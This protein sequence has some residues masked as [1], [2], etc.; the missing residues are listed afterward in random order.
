MIDLKI[1]LID[2]NPIYIPEKGSVDAACYDV[3]AREIIKVNDGYYKVKLGFKSEIPVGFDG[4][5]V[6]RS[7]ITDTG[8]FIPNSPGTIDADFRGEWQ[9][10]FRAQP[11]GTKWEMVE[12]EI[13]CKDCEDGEECETM[14]VPITV[15]TYPEFPYKV[16]DR[17][18]QFKLNK[19]VDTKITTVASLTDTVRGEGGYG[20]T[21]VK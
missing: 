20:S 17:V 13:G 7:S 6:P 9:A 15:L 19:L 2:G 16:E 3:R 18:A 14:Q 8:W 1:E 5:L 10:R 21:G 4:G 11:N 12:V